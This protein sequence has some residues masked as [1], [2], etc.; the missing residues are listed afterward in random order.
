MSRFQARRQNFI[1]EKNFIFPREK[2]G[3]KTSSVFILEEALPRNSLL[4][5]VLDE[6]QEGLF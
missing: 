4:F 6:G 1:P 3:Y 2:L 5:A